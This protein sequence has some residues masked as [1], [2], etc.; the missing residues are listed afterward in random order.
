M[1]DAR[2]LDMINQYSLLSVPFIVLV[3][4]SVLLALRMGD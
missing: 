4:M 1:D 2:I 3:F